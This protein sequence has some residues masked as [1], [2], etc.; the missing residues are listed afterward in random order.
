M[1]ARDLTANCIPD[2]HAGA[3]YV[4]DEDADAIVHSD[5]Y[6]LQLLRSLEQDTGTIGKKKHNLKDDD[7]KSP[8]LLML[9]PG[10]TYK[11]TQHTKGVVAAKEKEVREW[12]RQLFL[13]AKEAKE[14]NG[15][16]HEPKITVAMLDGS[17]ASK[18]SALERLVERTLLDPLRQ[19]P[20]QLQYLKRKVGHWKAANV[21]SIP[22]V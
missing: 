5:R 10:R 16:D 18:P 12:Q 1:N 14:S 2:A 21:R 6:Y 13:C 8:Y 19:D 22:E 7:A 20:A 3:D 4:D 9:R 17:K 15:S 11:H